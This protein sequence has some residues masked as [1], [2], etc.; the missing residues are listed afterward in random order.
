MKGQRNAAAAKPVKQ[1]STRTQLSYFRLSL[2]S[3]ISHHRPPFPQ[4]IFTL[5]NR[6]SRLSVTVSVLSSTV[7]SVQSTPPPSPENLSHSAQFDIS[8]VQLCYLNVRSIY[9]ED[10]ISHFHLP[11]QLTTNSTSVCLCECMHVF[12]NIIVS[13]DNRSFNSSQ[14]VFCNKTKLHTFPRHNTNMLCCNEPAICTFQCWIVPRHKQTEPIIP[15]YLT[16]FLIQTRNL[17]TK[18]KVKRLVCLFFCETDLVPNNAHATRSK[19]V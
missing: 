8:L 12:A 16:T 10:I 5:S 15:C 14:S 6:W 19:V 18:I 3:N 13:F 4:S 1:I 2:V 17:L 11:V 7:H 9:L